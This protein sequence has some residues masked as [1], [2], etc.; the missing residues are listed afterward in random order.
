[1]LATDPE[2]FLERAA[3]AE[4]GL[5]WSQLSPDLFENDHF[6]VRIFRRRLA[7]E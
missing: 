4:T 1:M 5:K 7:C 6:R 2:I 3:E